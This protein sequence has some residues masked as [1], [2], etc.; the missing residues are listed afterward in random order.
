MSK[1]T[2]LELIAFL[3]VVAS[4]AGYMGYQHYEYEHNDVSLDFA[5]AMH[6]DL[7]KN[8]SINSDFSGIRK[9]VHDRKDKDVFNEFIQGVRLAEEADKHRKLAE[10][11][12]LAGIYAAQLKNGK[13]AQFQQQYIEQKN[14]SEAWADKGQ[15]LMDDVNQQVAFAIDRGQTIK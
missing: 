11:A 5:L 12:S 14:Q 10:D 4:I 3:C 15:T 2:L 7:G 8:I 1:S 6:N 13:A 9:H